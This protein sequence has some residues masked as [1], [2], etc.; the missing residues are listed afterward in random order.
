MY[1]FPPTQNNT[2]D[3]LQDMGARLADEVVNLIEPFA[4][5]SRRPLTSISFV[6]HSIGNLILRSALTHPLMEPYLGLLLFYVSISGPHLGFMYSTN[7]ML[8][9]GVSVLKTLS[10]KGIRHPVTYVPAVVFYF[11]DLLV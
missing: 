2:G 6:G 10:S 11:D 9:A 4:T 8:D 7:T 1:Y 5:S 3:S